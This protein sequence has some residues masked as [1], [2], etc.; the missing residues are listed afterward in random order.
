MIRLLIDFACCKLNQVEVVDVPVAV[1]NPGVNFVKPFHLDFFQ[2]AFAITQLN[3]YS[4]K[5]CDYDLGCCVGFR[6]TKNIFNETVLSP[7]PLIASFKSRKIDPK[8]KLDL[9]GLLQVVTKCPSLF[10]PVTM[11]T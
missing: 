2:K 10:D 5:E 8:E 3:T 9:K 1:M 4:C 11:K 7:F 6:H